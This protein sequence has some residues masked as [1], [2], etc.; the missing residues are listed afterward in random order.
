MDKQSMWITN[1]TTSVKNIEIETIRARLIKWRNNDME[2]TE[3][4]IYP[5]S[6]HWMM[7]PKD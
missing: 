5:L 1:T 4:I 7:R 2:I 6:I 3:S